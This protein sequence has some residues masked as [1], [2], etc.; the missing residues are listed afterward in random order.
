MLCSLFHASILLVL[1]NGGIFL[2]KDYTNAR[3]AYE[4]ALKQDPHNSILKANLQ[5]LE[6]AAAQASRT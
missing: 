3:I 5:K 6:R 1:C 2:Q 4:T